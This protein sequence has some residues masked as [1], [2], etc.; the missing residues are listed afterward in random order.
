MN[1]RLLYLFVILLTG[2]SESKKNSPNVFFGGEIV[3]PTSKYVVLYKG[4]AVIDSSALD[5]NNMFSFQF[6]SIEDGLYHFKHAP[7]LQYVYLDQGDSLIV[8]LNT[9]D[10]DESLVFSGT[11]EEINNFMLEIFLANESEKNLIDAY[12]GLE[13]KDFSRKIDSLQQMKLDLL[14][15]LNLEFPLTEKEIEIAQAD[16]VY[17][18]AKYRERYPFKYRRISKENTAPK[19]SDDYYAYRNDLTYNNR[20]LTYLRPYYEF[21]VNH[22]GNLSYMSCTHGCDIKDNMAK[23]H[24]HFNKHKLKLIDSLVVEKELKDNLFRN[25]AVDYL[26]KVHDSEENIKIFMEVFHALSDNNRHIDE[27]NDLYEGIMNIQPRKKIPNIEVT[28]INGENVSLPSIAKD[29]KTVFY[30][31]SGANKKHLR[32]IS[33]QISRLSQIEPTYKFVGIN[34]QTNSDEWKSLLPTSGF[35]AE[36]QYRSDNFEYLTKALIVYPMNKC[37]ITDNDLIVDAFGDIY[38]S[39]P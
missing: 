29:G 20:D 1:K 26:L 38:Q 2:C 16:I 18:Y 35:N 8:R 21:M 34:V 9:V 24:L 4:D 6:D 22:F 15:D 36:N 25:V 17:N 10:F 7:E 30:F 28:N 33:K 37:I 23:N 11:G 39:F 13:S 5:K 27:I 3:N 31:W 19:L 12:Y 14:S 32:D